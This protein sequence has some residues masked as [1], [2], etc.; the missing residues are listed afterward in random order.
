[1]QTELL[2]RRRPQCSARLLLLAG[3]AVL[4]A[5]GLPAHAE[6]GNRAAA[7][8]SA[9]EV[10]ADGVTSNRPLVIAAATR[11]EPPQHFDPKMGMCM[12]GGGQTQPKATPARPAET[13]PSADGAIAMRAAS[14]PCPADQRWDP[15]M[16][17]CAPGEA[18]PKASLMLH[19]N[20]F[21]VYSRTTGPRGQSRWT[22]PG[23]WMLTY[24][25]DIT[26]KNHLSIAVMAS[27]EP[28]TVGDKGTPQLLQTEHID[29]MHAHDT[30][31]ALEFRDAVAFGP[32]D[33]QKLTFL[34]APRGQAAIGPVPFMH[35]ESAEGNPDAP[36]GHALQ[37]GFH[38]AS[39]VVGVAYQVARTTFE[40]TG[41]SGQGITRP[42]PIHRLD[43]Y[44]LRFNRDI[45]DHVRVGAS[46]ADALL[47]DDAGGAQHNQFI[48]A[49]L[50]TSH[51]RPGAALKTA[52]IWGETRAGH[53]AFLSSFLEEALYQRGKNNFYGRAETLQVTP[54]QLELV[55]ANG[56]EGARWVEAFTVGY[57]RALFTRNGLSVFGGGSYTKDLV[58]TAFRPGYGSDPAGAKL[59]MRLRYMGGKLWF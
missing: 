55:T 25:N 33:G 43:S 26:A 58:P 50:T 6:Q 18:A 2:G 4:V 53:D 39:T 13:V 8:P 27:P 59:Y 14:S 48:S 7:K 44:S 47:P 40:V 41:F 45:D 20:Q 1:M 28:W 49:W 54:S 57:E 9:P 52:F 22:G 10:V 34:F 21:A 12:T 37:D 51:G 35:R 32:G 36:L 42:F 17:M 38:D 3:C 56:A 11:C 5:Y 30:V 24:D 16:N 15:G 46:F 31:M 19:L 23:A 29:N